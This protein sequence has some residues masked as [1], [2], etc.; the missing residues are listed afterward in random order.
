MFGNCPICDEAFGT[1]FSPEFT[2]R[3]TPRTSSVRGRLTVGL[4]L[5]G[6]APQGRPPPRRCRC[7]AHTQSGRLLRFF[8]L[9]DLVALGDHPVTSDLAIA[10]EQAADLLPRQLVVPSRVPIRLGSNAHEKPPPFE[11]HG[12]RPLRPRASRRT[13]SPGSGHDQSGRAA[14][15]GLAPAMRLGRE[16]FGLRAAPSQNRERRAGGGH[17]RP[18]RP[19]QGRRAGRSRMR[20]PACRSFP[21]ANSR[22]SARCRAASPRARPSRSASSSRGSRRHSRA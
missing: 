18:D 10:V 4:Q 12:T 6:R 1:H 11:R 8:D 21:A 14:A 7:S 9:V 17:A 2:F 20:V 19:G 13:F 3:W 22:Q 16:L 5:R 15:R